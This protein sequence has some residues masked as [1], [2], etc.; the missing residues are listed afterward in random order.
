[1][2]VSIKS[3]EAERKL[4]RISRLLGKSLTATVIDLADARLK[5]IEAGKDR[6]RRLKAI[7]VIV[8]RVKSRPI[9]STA[10]ENEILGYNDKGYFD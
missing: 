5:E 6:E 3:A 8:R 1:M 10:S 2:G 9:L 4:R 7:D